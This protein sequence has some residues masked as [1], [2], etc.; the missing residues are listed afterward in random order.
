MGI[1]WLLCCTVVS[2]WFCV[3]S[4]QWSRQTWQ[5]TSGLQQGTL[6][7]VTSLSLL[8][9]GW[10]CFDL[11]G[12]LDSGEPCCSVGFFYCTANITLSL[13]PYI[14][15]MP[16]YPCCFHHNFLYWLRQT[17]WLDSDVDLMFILCNVVE[18]SAMKS[19]TSLLHASQFNTILNTGPFFF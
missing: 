18:F 15:H 19:A 6:Q 7:W 11:F 5:P 3:L 4:T 10:S 8:V 1:A 13:S 17:G 14:Y 9:T 16:L 12:L 2:S